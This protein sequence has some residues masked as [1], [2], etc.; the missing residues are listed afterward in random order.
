M[1]ISGIVG[2]FMLR[3]G[4]GPAPLI[5]GMILGKIVEETFSQ[6]M[7]IH[8]NNFFAIADR[9]I[10]LLF[11]VLTLLSLFGPFIGGWWARL[12]GARG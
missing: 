12:R 8:D 5:M 7:I 6:S 4:F 10:V 1:L 11:F 3:F 9:P 2:Y